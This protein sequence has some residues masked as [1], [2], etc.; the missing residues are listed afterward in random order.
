[1]YQNRY[2]TQSHDV[3]FYYHILITDFIYLKNTYKTENYINKA[4]KNPQP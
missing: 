4:N 2:E 3:H 1:M